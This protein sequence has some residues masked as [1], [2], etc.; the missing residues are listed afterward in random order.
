[1]IRSKARST[2]AIITLKYVKQMQ[3]TRQG[4]T[5]F[6]QHLVKSLLFPLRRK[7]P[8]LFENLCGKKHSGHS[9]N[10]PDKCFLYYYSKSDLAGY[11]PSILHTTNLPLNKTALPGKAPVLEHLVHL[12]ETQDSYTAGGNTGF[13]HCRMVI[14]SGCR[15]NYQV[16]QIP[17]KC[18]NHRYHRCRC[19]LQS[20]QDPLNLKSSYSLMRSTVK[21]KS[22]NFQILD[23]SHMPSMALKPLM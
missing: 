14:S 20:F 21:L 16:K 6:C 15:G 4:Y 18:Q 22:R 3:K 19:T 13:L 23:F 10:T 11:G 1:M 9:H 8:K 5:P 12:L 17:Y 7:C 2:I